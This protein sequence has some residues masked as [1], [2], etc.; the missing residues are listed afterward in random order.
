MHKVIC[1]RCKCLDMIVKMDQ[2]IVTVYCRSCRKIVRQF[3][4]REEVIAWKIDSIVWACRAVGIEPVVKADDSEE[5]RGIVVE[6]TH[7]QGEYDSD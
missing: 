6:I 7:G 3:A 1:G 5:F 4:V 2:D